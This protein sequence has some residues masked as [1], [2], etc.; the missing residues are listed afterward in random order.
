VVGN[1][2]SWSFL[3]GNTARRQAI[4]QFGAAQSLGDTVSVVNIG[5]LAA[6]GAA[7]HRSVDCC[8]FCC[9]IGFGVAIT[10][11]RTPVVAMLWMLPLL[12]FAKYRGW[13]RLPIISSAGLVA[14]SFALIAS[15][16][17]ISRFL[18]LTL[19]AGGGVERLSLQDLRLE[20]WL[21][22]LK[23]IEQSPWVGY[24]WYQTPLAQLNVADGTQV[25][26][27]LLPS[28]HN[29]VLDL[30]L[31]LGIPLAMILMIAMAWSFLDKF[32][33]RRGVVG[34]A[35]WL[36][37]AVILNH[38]MLEYAEL[39][40]YFFAPACWWLGVLSAGSGSRLRTY[41]VDGPGFL[42]ITDCP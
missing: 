38:S 22:A 17:D 9:A 12:A 6:L 13:I 28:T 37:V 4:R 15:I 26:G 39:Y 3:Y 29:L 24:G 16:G 41:K 18:Y 42:W 5:H 7:T 8:C 35:A 1:G 32:N 10:F 33:A 14:L 31:W 36:G 11:S 20:I 21:D 19:P 25:L 2:S 40:A 30:T 34:I 27:Q 23:A